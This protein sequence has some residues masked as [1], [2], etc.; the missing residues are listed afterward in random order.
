MKLEDVILEPDT[1]GNQ[2]AANSVPVG[3]LYCVSDESDIVERSDGA[4]WVAYSPTGGGSGTVTNTGTLTNNTLLKGNGGVDV[5]S[6]TTGTGILTALG[7]N[8]GSA[9][10]PALVNGAL[11][12]PSSGVA[13]N[14]TGLPTVT[15]LTGKRVVQQVNTTTGTQSSGTTVVP[16]DNTK[17]QNTEGDEYITLAITPTSA[18]HK[19]K[20]EVVVFGSF[21]VSAWVIAALFQDTTADALAAGWNYQQT[22][23]AACNVTFTYYMTSGTTSATTFKVRVGGHTAGTYTFNGASGGTTLSLG[24]VLASS[25]T[26]TEYAPS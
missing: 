24:G 15:G 6:V 19:L 2:P 4:S 17:P 9:G 16:I 5:S 11:G 21:S 20:I 3:T 13:T 12:T 10:A 18:T 7:V 22:G 26:I 23:T 25:I 14:L 1:R 8:V